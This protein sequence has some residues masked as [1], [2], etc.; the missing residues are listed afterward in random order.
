MTKVE[1]TQL[2][3]VMDDLKMADGVWERA[4]CGE[5][6]RSAVEKLNVLIGEPQPTDDKVA[7]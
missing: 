1:K 2:Q 3:A 7:G 6:I 5:Y 4:T